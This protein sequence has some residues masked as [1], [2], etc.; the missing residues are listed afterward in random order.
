MA[1]SHALDFLVRRE[2]L[3][4][5]RVAPAAESDASRLEP[6]QALLRVHRFG[7]TANNVTYAVVGE[8]MRYWE[9][10]PAP[11]GWGRVPVWGFGDVLR[12][13]HERVAEGERVFGYLPPS[14]HLVVRPDRAGPAGFVDASPH[15]AALP[16]VYNQYVRVASDPSYEPGHEAEQMLLRPL[17]VTSFLLEDFLAAE[18]FFGARTVLVS[19]ASS[20]T[21]IALAF[22]LSRNRTG[23]CEVVGLTSP[24]NVEFVE[25]LGCY[26]RVVPYAEIAS[27]PADRPVV[28]ADMAG[29]AE[30]RGALHRH[31]GDRVK[32]SALVGITHWERTDGAQEDLPGAP[33]SFF[34]A[35]TQIQ[36]RDREWGP[37]EVQSRIARAW[38][39]FV[40]FTAGWLRIV[41][42]R[43]PAALER[44]YRQV[45]EGRSRPDEGH[46]LSL[47]EGGDDEPGGSR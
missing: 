33:P 24:G 8:S 18:D 20:R 21:A 1:E 3:R 38:R 16:P 34:F 27:L 2:D 47:W 43:G 40:A 25:G 15:R 11:A 41:P 5:C 35:P 28:I 17:F 37:G 31:F 4:Q 29:N 36:K 19:S 44:V 22:L 7:F 23:E 39:P 9:F 12:S 10:F 14:T 45:L 13:R 6:G 26:D 30:L 42:G 46:V 32:H